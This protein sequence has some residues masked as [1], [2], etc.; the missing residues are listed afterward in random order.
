M[1]LHFLHNTVNQQINTQLSFGENWMFFILYLSLGNVTL[2]QNEQQ[3]I[4]GILKYE[5][6]MKFIN[7]GQFSRN[8]ESLIS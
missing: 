5:L 8:I 7:H 4:L 3:I 6:Q 1:L 2:E